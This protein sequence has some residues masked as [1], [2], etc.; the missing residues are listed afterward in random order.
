ALAITKADPQILHTA[1]AGQ[2]LHR[3]HA[4]GTSRIVARVHRSPIAS[5]S[6]SRTSLQHASIR[7]G[8][9]A[10]LGAMSLIKVNSQPCASGTISTVTRSK[11][12]APFACSLRIKPWL[13]N[14]L[15]RRAESACHPGTDLLLRVD[16]HGSFSVLRCKKK[17]SRRSDRIFEWLGCTVNR[18]GDRRQMH[19]S[20]R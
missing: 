6:R 14:E 20:W 2:R 1:E 8:S 3:C 9:P 5:A 4:A 17:A 12:C 7:L 15:G 18:A 19:H 10:M 11:F 13:E 16:G